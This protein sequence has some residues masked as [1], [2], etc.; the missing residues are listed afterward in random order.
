[1]EKLT[2]NESKVLDFMRGN[3][4]PMTN[5]ENKREVN[6]RNGIKTH[7]SVENLEW[8]T[9]KENQ[10]HARTTG[11]INDCGENNTRSLL[12][13]AQANEMRELYAKGNIIQK[14]IAVIYGITQSQVSEIILY[15]SYKN[16]DRI[17]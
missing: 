11:L 15:K 5:P 12:T 8:V 16:N 13:N 10:H 4:I 6:H 9:P 1:M 14:E 7:N 17:N 2:K 3:K